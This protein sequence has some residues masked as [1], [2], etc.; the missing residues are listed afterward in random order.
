MQLLLKAPYHTNTHTHTTA[1]RKHSI[2]QAFFRF[3][4][5]FFSRFHQRD[6]PEKPYKPLQYVAH[7][8]CRRRQSTPPTVDPPQYDET[9][10]DASVVGHK[11]LEQFSHVLEL[12]CGAISE[13]RNL[14]HLPL[15]PC[16]VGCP[17][18]TIRALCG[19]LLL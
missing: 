4:G 14:I 10:K 16:N 8:I 11:Q 5:L 18:D 1:T 6:P 19:L 3:S 13:K 7:T 9:H 12:V 17:G 15:R 2:T